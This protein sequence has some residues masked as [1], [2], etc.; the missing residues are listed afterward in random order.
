LPV[1][2]PIAR[3]VDFDLD[4]VNAAVQRGRSER[5]IVFV[6]YEFRDLCISAVEIFAILGKVRAA[7]G[8]R[9]NLAQGTVGLSEAL[10]Q[11]GLVFL[12]LRS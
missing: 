9:R 2:D 12:F 6:P 7:A 10:F 5:K 11:E 4:G 1:I 8:S 3:F